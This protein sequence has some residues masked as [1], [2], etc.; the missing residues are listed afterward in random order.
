[1]KRRGWLGAAALVALMSPAVA[2]AQVET[3]DYRRTDRRVPES[4]QRFAFELRLGPYK[5][6]IDEEFNGRTPFADTFGNGKGFHIGAEIDWQALRIPYLGTLGPGFSWGYTSRSAKARISGTGKE[7]AEETS[8]SIMP[9][10]LVGV[11]RLDVLPREF[12]VPVVPYGKL[13]LGLGLWSIST[14]KGTVT[15]DGVQG[16]GRSWGTHAAVG[17]M[18]HLDFLERDV[19]LSF[20]DELGVNNSYLFFEW[21]WS[22]LGSSG[23]IEDRPQ[24][25]VGTSGWVLGLAFEM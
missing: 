10:T 2:E 13:G 19:A 15:R 20:D 5:P 21:M 7:S 6:R 14:S 3:R 1:M 9:M 12:H 22:D 18:L 11:A 16:R 17:G 8:L 25:R 4:P 24:M 23:L